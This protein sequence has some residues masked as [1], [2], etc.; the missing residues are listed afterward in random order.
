MY[1]LG[2]TTASGLFQQAVRRGSFPATHNPG[3]E[4]SLSL[5]GTARPKKKLL[6]LPSAINT[7]MFNVTHTLVVV[8]VLQ[9]ISFAAAV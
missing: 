3:H 2:Q 7:P 4:T 5:P 6:R 9:S 1:V 8:V